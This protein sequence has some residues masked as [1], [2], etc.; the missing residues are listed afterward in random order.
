MRKLIILFLFSLP[1]LLNAQLELG[2]RAGLNM[3][4][5]DD[6]RATNGDLIKAAQLNGINAGVFAKFQI[7]SIIALQPE[8]T[9][10]KKGFVTSWDN[11]D[12]SSMLNTS[13]LD[14]PLMIE[15]GLAIG[16]RFRIFANAGP[17]VSYLIK[18]EEEFYDSMNGETTK[19]AFNFDVE[20]FERLDVGVNFGGGI[21]LRTRRW[22]Y[23]LNARYNMGLKEIMSNKDAMSFVENAK[24]RVTNIS[25]GISYF[26]FGGRL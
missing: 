15:A 5:A 22:K 23:T 6:L 13:Y 10:S 25:L 12:S 9:F 24:Y 18:A 3:S 26:V 17:N 8:V 7:G 21:S 19:T 1:T 2:F 20:S 16:K 14:M 11:S 4:E